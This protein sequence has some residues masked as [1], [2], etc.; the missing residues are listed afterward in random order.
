MRVGPHPHALSLAGPAAPG[1]PPAARSGRRRYL[2]SS[3]TTCTFA[4]SRV[5]WGAV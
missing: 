3:N 4:R 2:I 5:A 1:F